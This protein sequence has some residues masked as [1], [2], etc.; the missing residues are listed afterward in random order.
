MAISS[1]PSRWLSGQWGKSIRCKFYVKAGSFV[2]LDYYVALSPQI[3]EPSRFIPFKIE[4][5]F[6]LMYLTTPDFHQLAL[7]G[8]T[9]YS[10]MQY[11]FDNF[12]G[13]TES[14]FHSH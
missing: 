2:L 12:L 13:K 11:L 14:V 10:I 3:Q 1:R 6:L 9:H 5:F 8:I 4:F 7:F